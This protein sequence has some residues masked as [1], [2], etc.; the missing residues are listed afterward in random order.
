MPGWFRRDSRSP[1]N[2]KMT[3]LTPNEIPSFSMYN[4]SDERVKHHFKHL[5]AE[6]ADG[7]ERDCGLCIQVHVICQLCKTEL[8]T[9]W[10]AARQAGWAEIDGN[11]LCG[12]CSPYDYKPY[13]WR[14]AL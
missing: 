8:K 10:G 7:I 2:F 4:I 12:K 1:G 11:D 3:E 6:L 9:S 14:M 5:H 13:E